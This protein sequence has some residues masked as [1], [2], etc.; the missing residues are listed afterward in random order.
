VVRAVERARLRG[1]AASPSL[2]MRSTLSQY[3]TETDRKTR[4]ISLERPGSPNEPELAAVIVQNTAPWTYLG[5]R[6]INACPDASFD[7]GLDLMAMRALNVIATTRAVTQLLSP[8]S[9][10]SGR[11]V[12]TLHDLGEF[13]LRSHR[14]LAFQLDGDYLGE[15]TKVTFSAVPEALRVFC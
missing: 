1:R 13:T 6:S 11:H 10:P 12:L 9:S 2:Y 3:L 8:H 7:T 15:R 4:L 5:E 14:P